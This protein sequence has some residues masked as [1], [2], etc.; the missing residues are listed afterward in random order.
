MAGGSGKSRRPSFGVPSCRRGG[1]PAVE[2]VEDR[3]DGWPQFV[4]D[5][6]LVLALAGAAPG[7]GDDDLEHAASI[8]VATRV[9]APVT[10]SALVAAG[11]M[12]V[13]IFP[14]SAS[15]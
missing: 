1:K 8:G 6:V 11:L 7:L 14:S 15:A 5:L 2:V 10:A 4:G 3:F 12:S 9:I 13:L